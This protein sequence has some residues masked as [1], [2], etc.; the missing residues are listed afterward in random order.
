MEVLIIEQ[1]S[2][3]VRVR[4]MITTPVAAQLLGVT[5]QGVSKMIHR[6]HFKSA[7]RVGIRKWLLDRA[8]V[9]NGP[10]ED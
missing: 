1:Q 3:A 10:F 7:R 6:G 2:A 5:R 4:N 9:V 8:E